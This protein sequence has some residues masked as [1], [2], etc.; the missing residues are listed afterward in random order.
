M[1]NEPVAPLAVSVSA[2]S[3]SDHIAT[4]IA[5]GADFDVRWVA[6]GRIH[7]Q[8]M[9]RRFVVW[10]SVLAMGAALVSAF[11]RP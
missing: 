2:V 5:P 10:A 1:I 9:R 11:L 4:A 6:R 3:V 8:R 7:D